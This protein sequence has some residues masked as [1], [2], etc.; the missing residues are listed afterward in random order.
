VNRRGKR[1]RVGD[2]IYRDKIGLAGIVTMGTGDERRRKEKRF[3]RHTPHSEI[4]DW[5]AA[6]RS[7]W[8]ASGAGGST[9]GTL[10]A[11]V[12]RYLGLVKHLAGWIEL[13]ANL[14]AWVKLHGPKRRTQITEATI[15]ETRNRWLRDGLKPKTV[16]N[17][18]ADLNRLWHRLDGKRSPSPCD[19][20][21][22]LHV[23]K[24]PPQR[25]PDTAVLVVYEQLRTW[26]AAGTLRDAKSRARFMVYASTGN[27]PSE[28]M[29]AEPSDVDFE[30]RV[31]NVRDGKGGWSPGIYLN[32]DMLCAWQLFAKADAWGEFS[33]NSFV[34]LIRKAGWPEDVRP[35]NLRHTVGIAL[36]EFGVDLADIQQ[37]MG[38][39][40]IETTR[41]HYVPVLGSRL[42]AAS[43]LLDHRF[44]WSSDEDRANTV[45]PLIAP[46][47]SNSLQ[48]QDRESRASKAKA[49]RS[50]PISV[51][52]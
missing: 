49:T 22:P 37:H 39:R 18:V 29:R 16:N 9:K 34:R 27:R 36:S 3:D 12:D 42:Q 23:H 20:V 46:P 6:W 2:G 8:R 40:R 21:T 4:K 24:V 10:A 26:E 44:G 35:Y 15:L 38:H 14:R 25:I 33:G 13:R 47:R 7:R 17:R 48:T 31:W 11:D 43:E 32:D 41:R 45:P 30:R 19:N 52:K 28:I 1:V 5:Q 50:D 51:A